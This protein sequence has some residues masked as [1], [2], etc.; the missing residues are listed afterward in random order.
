MVAWPVAVPGLGG[1]LQPCLAPGLKQFK[2]GDSQERVFDGHGHTHP[3]I[4]GQAHWEKLQGSAD[5]RGAFHCARHVTLAIGVATSRAV[6]VQK[7]LGNTAC[8]TNSAYFFCMLA[9]CCSAR[10][11]GC[12]IP[13]AFC[14][15]AHAGAPVLTRSATQLSI[16]S[17]RQP[18]A[19]VD[20]R[21]GVTNVPFF[22][23][24]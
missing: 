6:N 3:F 11:R 18:T 8:A 21:T 5:Q 16:S 1:V 9:W 4:A 17:S 19:R 14:T 7:H 24:A 15:L 10:L 12:A 13:L 2:A 23:P 20:R 22:T